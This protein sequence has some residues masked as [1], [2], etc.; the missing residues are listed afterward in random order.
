[1]PQEPG[2]PELES[3]LHR[4]HANSAL[5]ISAVSVAWTVVSSGLA[6]AI[7]IASHTAVLVAFG[8]V[9]V[10]DA[11]GSIALVYHFHHSLRHDELSDEL[12]KIAHRVVL[13][14]LFLVGCSAVLG[15]LVRLGA[16]SSD[17]S[18]N[19]GVVLAAVSLV[20]LTA[21]SARKQQI[22]R[23]IS[24]NA[25]LSDGHLSAVGAML[26]AVTL[27]GTVTTRVLGWHW[28]DAA[29]TILVGG[30]AVWLAASTWRNEHG[31]QRVA[32]RAITFVGIAV[33]W[34]A[35][36]TVVD[37]LLGP[38]LIL[39]GLLVGG[40]A[41][42]AISC[43]PRPVAAIGAIAIVLSVLLGAPDQIWF[44]SE[45]ASWISAVVIVSVVNSIVVALVAPQIQSRRRV[46][47]GLPSEVVF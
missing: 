21:L 1:M 30:V 26:A 43:R 14:G 10:V 29:A 2:Q 20:V 32:D 7:G 12:E 18:S 37:A 42:A 45:H 33:M 46:R 11:I 47:D 15:G 25:L 24:S 23:R 5:R 28:A 36:V 3:G 13:V 39:I 31:Q 44:Y 6:I 19:V 38:R 41:L 34:L 9:G 35:I 8:A 27:A 40:P 17:D 22:A 16:T 4:P